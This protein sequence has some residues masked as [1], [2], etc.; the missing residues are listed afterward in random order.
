MAQAG[1]EK[2][3]SLEKR[4]TGCKRHGKQKKK[5]KERSIDQI[6]ID[7][8]RSGRTGKYLAFGNT[9]R[10]VR[11]PWPRVKYFPV[12]PSCSV[13][14]SIIMFQYFFFNSWQSI[15]IVILYIKRE[16]RKSGL[17]PWGWTS[18]YMHGV[19][20]VLKNEIR[21]TVFEGLTTSSLFFLSS[22]T[23]HWSTTTSLLD[24]KLSLNRAQLILQLP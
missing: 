8:V 17:P 3:H 1:C 9:L 5:V 13:N 18:S 16:R 23:F 4:P 19:L 15:S 11:T 20:Q 21:L 7:W 6:P 12:W 2:P 14:K 22:I 10:S 24:Q